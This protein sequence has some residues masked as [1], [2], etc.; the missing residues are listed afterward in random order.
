MNWQVPTEMEGVP[1]K[2]CNKSEQLQT[3]GTHLD[4]LQV[5]GNTGSFCSLASWAA[6]LRTLLKDLQ[7]KHV[8]V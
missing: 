6:R 1:A 4:L 2:C 7:L 3:T 5:T 8:D